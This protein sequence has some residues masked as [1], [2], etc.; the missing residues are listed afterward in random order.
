MST[1]AMLGCAAR[2]C[3]QILF[4]GIATEPHCCSAPLLSGYRFSN[5]LA[6]C[7]LG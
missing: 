7:R 4:G 5:M 2:A 3:F 1:A 6:S